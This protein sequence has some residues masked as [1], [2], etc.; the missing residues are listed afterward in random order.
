MR[1]A[2][3]PSARDPDGHRRTVPPARG[4]P[5]YFFAPPPP[6]SPSTP[7]GCPLTAAGRLPPTTAGRQQPRRLR[8]GLARG[9]G[10]STGAPRRRPVAGSA[11]GRL[12]DHR[13]I[14]PFGSI[15]EKNRIKYFNSISKLQHSKR[16]RGLPIF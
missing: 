11:V 4:E 10:E 7:P 8:A 6:P 1:A 14:T 12:H 5:G 16:A 15:I 2:E 3:R 13:C 9:G